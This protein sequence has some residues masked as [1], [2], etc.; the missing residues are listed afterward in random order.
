MNVLYTIAH[1]AA[2]LVFAICLAI[3]LQSWYDVLK[4]GP[5]SKSTPEAVESYQS[6]LILFGEFAMRR[7]HIG[8]KPDTEAYP[9]PGILDF[10][11]DAAEGMKAHN[12]RYP[13]FGFPGDP[14]YFEQAVQSCCPHLVIRDWK[15]KEEIEFALAVAAFHQDPDLLESLRLQS[16][17]RR[18]PST[19]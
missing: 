11:R 19:A 7:I 1:I 18:L 8:I 15:A 17:H 6:V 9:H 4:K 10:A 5:M 12:A 2:W 13:K 16:L 14:E 3:V